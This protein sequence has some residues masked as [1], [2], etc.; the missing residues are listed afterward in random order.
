MPQNITGMIYLIAV[1]YKQHYN[2]KNGSE[3]GIGLTS[4]DRLF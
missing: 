2:I 3:L 1:I 4:D